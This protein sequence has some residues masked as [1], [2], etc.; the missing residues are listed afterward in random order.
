MGK[1]PAKQ[2]ESSTNERGDY[3][4]PLRLL[5]KYTI[6]FQLRG[7]TQSSPALEKNIHTSGST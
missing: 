5:H 1:N 2:K 7:E 4:W 3:A 6:V